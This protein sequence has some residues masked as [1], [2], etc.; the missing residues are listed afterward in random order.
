[1][2]LGFEM[3]DL[4]KNLEQERWYNIFILHNRGKVIPPKHMCACMHIYVFHVQE[5]PS[6]PTGLHQADKNNPVS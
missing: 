2:Q 6:L 1:M 4:L 5:K 3:S